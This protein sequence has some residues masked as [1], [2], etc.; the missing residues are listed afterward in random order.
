MIYYIVEATRELTFHKEYTRLKDAEECINYYRQKFGDACAN[1]FR[2]TREKRVGTNQ[3]KS[4][5]DKRKRTKYD[6][7]Y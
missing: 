5:I 6:R 3:A 4:L 1:I 2:I 7:R